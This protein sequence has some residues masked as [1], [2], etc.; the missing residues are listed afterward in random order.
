MYFTNA[1]TA[2]DMIPI[3]RITKIYGIHNPKHVNS[4]CVRFHDPAICEN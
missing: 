4:Q 3:K 1:I 2:N